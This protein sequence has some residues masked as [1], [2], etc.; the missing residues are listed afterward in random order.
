MAINGRTI[1]SSLDKW[2]NNHNATNTKQ[3][4]ADDC[5]KYLI[6]WEDKYKIK[7]GELK[8]LRIQEEKA[9]SGFATFFFLF[10]TETACAQEIC[11]PI[12]FSKFLIF[13]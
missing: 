8:K 12:L 4:C 13:F 6:N 2:R 1:L 7:G 9:L 3:S 11:G 10:L 5:E